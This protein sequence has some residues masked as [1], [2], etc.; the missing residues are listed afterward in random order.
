MPLRVGVVGVGGTAGVGVG[1]TTVGVI[2]GVGVA[3]A[4]VGVGVGVTG[5]MGDDLS[6][7]AERS[8]AIP[9]A[10]RRPGGSFR[11][12]TIELT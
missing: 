1:N 5:S 2:P 6:P 12:R 4:R 11:V 10:A 3:A 9:S 8:T 7:Q